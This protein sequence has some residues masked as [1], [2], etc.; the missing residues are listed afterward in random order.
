MEEQ[1]TK[2]AQSLA[3]VVAN[4]DDL[5]A[6]RPALEALGARHAGYG[7]L[8]AHYA[9]VRDTL[10]EVM[11]EMAGEL[12]NDTLRDDWTG[13]INAVAEAMLDGATNS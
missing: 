12:W 13:A 8:P 2:L 11:A 6:V 9:V 4:I 5:T 1:K 7:A 3:T 10:L